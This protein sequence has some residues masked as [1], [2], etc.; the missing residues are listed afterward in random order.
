M[1][2]SL[3]RESVLSFL[4]PAKMAGRRANKRPEESSSSGEPEWRISGRQHMVESHGLT[5]T[6]TTEDFEE[7][8]VAM[9][10]TAMVGDQR[11]SDILLVP[12]QE[13]QKKKAEAK[14]KAREAAKRWLEKRAAKPKE[15][16]TVP[17][18]A[19]KTTEEAAK[20]TEETAKATEETAKTTEEAP[21]VPETIEE[22]A[23]RK[24]A[25][26]VALEEALWAKE[27]EE[28]KKKREAEKTKMPQAP[29]VKKKPAN[30]KVRPMPK[31]SA[32]RLGVA[33]VHLKSRAQRGIPGQVDTA[34]RM[35]SAK[36]KEKKKRGYLMRAVNNALKRVP[37]KDQGGPPLRRTWAAH[38]RDH[39]AQ[40][41]EAEIK[42]PFVE[43]TISE[44]IKEPAS[45]P[46]LRTTP[47][48]GF[49]S[50][51]PMKVPK[52]KGSVG[53]EQ[54]LSLPTPPP[55]PARRRLPTPPRAPSPGTW[56]EVT[57]PAAK[58]GR[59]GRRSGG[60]SPVRDLE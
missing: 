14:E 8:T 41:Q 26:R 21:K 3:A 49:G 56:S 28:A 59:G 25:R 23:D 53:S 44:I 50:G 38:M 13:V 30:P 51:K 6:R 47:V 58:E 17:E 35:L 40:C 24:R 9:T 33:K 27:A 37:E 54:P 31:G 1:A 42:G 2:A 43:V 7:S 32:G 5:V 15:V 22:M 52:I 12:A 48:P 55:V 10:A 36:Q 20:A 4:I 34:L 19:A 46:P 39:L 11:G 60:R 16:I 18:E 45:P 29:V 57:A